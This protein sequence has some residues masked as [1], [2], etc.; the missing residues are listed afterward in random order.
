MRRTTII[1]GESEQLEKLLTLSDARTMASERVKIEGLP[2]VIWWVM[3]KGYVILPQ[4]KRPKW[5]FS[6]EEEL[7]IPPSE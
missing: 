1:R 5:F 3:D 4:G 6:S 7:L 2:Y